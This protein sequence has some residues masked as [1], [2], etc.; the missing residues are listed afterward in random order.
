LHGDRAVVAADALDVD[1]GR[2]GAFVDGVGGE[3]ETQGP[4]L[5][6]PATAHVDGAEHAG[7]RKTVVGAVIAERAGFVEGMR[8]REGRAAGAVG[9]ALV[10]GVDAVGAPGTVD[11]GHRIT[12][13]E[14][15]RVRMESSARSDGDVVV[16]G[17]RWRRGQEDGG[18]DRKS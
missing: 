2:P 4:R 9:V 16:G 3:A 13:G 8:E 6:S 7:P 11:P 12:D 17:P 1:G 5:A 15:E 10:V 14:R 18:E